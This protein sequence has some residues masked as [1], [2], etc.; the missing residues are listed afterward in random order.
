[1]RNLFHGFGEAPALMFDDPAF[2]KR[3]RLVGRIDADGQY[4]SPN[5]CYATEGPFMN[6]GSQ[7]TAAADLSASQF[8]GVKLTASRAVNL[9]TASTDYPYGVLQNKPKSGD[10][11][12]VVLV[13]ICKAKAGALITAGAKLMFNTSAQVITWVSGAGNVIAGQAIEG[14]SGTGVIITM[15][16]WPNKVNDA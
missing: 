16:V 10:A 14:A 5:V 11:A 4:H 15:L 12:D 8:L 13:G 7:V 1:M 3:D 6:D 9:I 2:R